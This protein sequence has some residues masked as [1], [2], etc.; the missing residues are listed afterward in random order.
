MNHGVKRLEDGTYEF[1]W[2]GGRRSMGEFNRLTYG[3]ASKISGE[4]DAIAQGMDIAASVNMG[5]EVLAKLEAV[6]EVLRLPLCE[7]CRKMIGAT[8]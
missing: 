6:E 8:S 4:V 5:K 2:L 7:S 1:W 3:L